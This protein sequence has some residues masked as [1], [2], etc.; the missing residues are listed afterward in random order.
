MTNRHVRPTL[1]ICGLALALANLWGCSSDPGRGLAGTVEG[2]EVAPP[3]AA[4]TAATADRAVQLGPDQPAPSGL[5]SEAAEISDLDRP[6]AELVALRCEHEQATYQCGECRYE[7]GM[8]KVDADLL[9]AGLVQT[10]LLSP[11][12]V[13]APFELAGQIAFDE[14][15]VAHVSPVVPGLVRKVWVDLGQ[16]VRAGQPLFE[17]ESSELAAAQ[18][19]W[20]EAQALLRLAEK[21]HQRQQA[22]WA[23]RVTSEREYLEA[24]Q[25]AAGAAV[26]QGMARQKLLR[27]GVTTAELET[28]EAQ[29]LADGAGHFTARA[30]LAGTVIGVQASFGELVE[31]G[32]DVVLLSDPSRLWVWA[33]LY[34]HQLA[35]VSGAWRSGA[36]AATVTV[37]AY[38]NEVF[39]GAVDF[40]GAA[41]ETASR[42]VRVRV[43]LNNPGDRLRPGMFARV[44]LYPQ[45]ERRSLVVPAV[46]VLSDEGRDFVFVH[47]DGDYFVRRPVQTGHAVGDLMEIRSGLATGQ[48]VVTAGAFLLKSDVLRS[49]MGAGCAD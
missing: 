30:P 11:Q 22:L 32:K 10:E 31:P 9:A 12:R 35:E 26:R 33:D 2:R 6:V 41:M 24:Q 34:E 21:S 18:G 5:P 20:L 37:E 3:A 39:S 43:S 7:I 14:R 36:L 23:E 13:S 29:G 28:L 1:V 48:R 15:R 47:H 25:A 40:V 46:A 16:Q 38:P 44:R 45:G 27:L 19:E 17:I 4:T 42:T 8:V 49:K